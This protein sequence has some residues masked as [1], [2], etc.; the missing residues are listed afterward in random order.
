[1]SQTKALPVKEKGEDDQNNDSDEEEDE[2]TEHREDVN[3]EAVEE[4]SGMKLKW[5]LNAWSRCSQTCGRGGKQ[6]FGGKNGNV[7]KI[8]L[9]HIYCHYFCYFAFSIEKWDVSS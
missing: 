1:M 8:I 6:V 5:K 9:E 4:E 7:F 3:D 2:D